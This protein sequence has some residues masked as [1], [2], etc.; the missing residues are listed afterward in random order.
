MA[1]KVDSSSNALLHQRYDDLYDNSAEFKSKLHNVVTSSRALLL[2]LDTGV[3]AAQYNPDNN[4]IKVWRQ[5]ATGVNKT[6]EELRDDIFFELHNAKKSM[7]FQD[8]KGSRG[9]NVAS[10]TSGSRKMAGWALAVEW[11]EW[12]NVAQCTV[13]ANIVNTQST[14]GR[15]LKSPPEFQ[16]CFSGPTTWLKFS[17]YLKTQVAGDHTAHY[18]PAASGTTWIGN[19]ILRV[20][21][22]R[23]STDLEITTNE[24]APTGRPPRLNS[25]GNP[26]TWELVNALELH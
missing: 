25:R 24:F 10:L 16:S 18:D 9:Y 8:L 12:I 14:A 5:S 6:D 7:A 21:A 2:V 15:L 1:P 11:T 13:T 22:T 20:V 17:N 4:S 23:S 19:D 26:F 3:G